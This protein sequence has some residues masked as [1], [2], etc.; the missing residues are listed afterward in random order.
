ML[1]KAPGG[2]DIDLAGNCTK[3]AQFLQHITGTDDRVGSKVFDHAR[4][5]A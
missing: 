3:E 2:A 1:H 4:I 5:Q